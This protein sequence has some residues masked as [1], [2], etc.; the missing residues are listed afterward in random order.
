[1][2]CGIIKKMREAQGER[3][4]DYS[5]SVIERLEERELAKIH[6]GENDTQGEHNQT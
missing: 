4:G 1:M 6:G 3:A 5:T 2:E